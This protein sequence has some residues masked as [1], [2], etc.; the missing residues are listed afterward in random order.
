MISMTEKAKKK[1]NRL[2]FVG[3]FL[4]GLA[5]FSY[6]LISQKYY[7]IKAEDE[8]IK[9]TTAASAIPEEEVERRM[10]LAKAYNDTLDP[11]RLSDP[12]TDMEKAGRAEYAR[13]L[14]IGRASC[15]ERV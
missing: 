9:F 7:E 10:A 8:V 3:I 14:E 12:Y 6:P 11:S 2:I 15:R 4:I 1:P 5:I 13:M